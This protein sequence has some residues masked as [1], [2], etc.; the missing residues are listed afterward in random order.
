M[1]KS[2]THYGVIPV[3]QG[4]ESVFAPHQRTD[5][6]FFRL[7]EHKANTLFIG[8]ALKTINTASLALKAYLLGLFEAHFVDGLT[9]S[10]GKGLGGKGVHVVCNP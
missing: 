10:C 9:R 6:A 2:I 1:L 7:P 4:N 8:L 5:V 3:N